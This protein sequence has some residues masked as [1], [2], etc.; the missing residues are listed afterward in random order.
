MNFKRVHNFKIV[1]GFQKM[2][3]NMKI[4]P[5]SRNQVAGVLALEKQEP[6]NGNMMPAA[7]P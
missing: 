3:M 4:V 1:H 2:L 7:S 6:E 5:K